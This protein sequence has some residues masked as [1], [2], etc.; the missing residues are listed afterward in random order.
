MNRRDFLSTILITCS[1]PAIVRAE[2]LMKI[3]VPSTAEVL[4]IGGGFTKAER[5]AFDRM[6]D[7]FED[8][9]VLSLP[10][11]QA[12]KRSLFINK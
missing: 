2:S 10:L 3:V 11:S 6:L 1:A 9:E 4:A 5:E 12:W 8:S 7:A